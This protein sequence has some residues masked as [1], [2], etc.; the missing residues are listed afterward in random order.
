M[1]EHSLPGDGFPELDEDA[2][3]DLSDL[4]RRLAVDNRAT[5]FYPDEPI[6][7]EGV[8]QEN[9]FNEFSSRIQED[10]DG[11]IWLGHLEHEF[12]FCGHTFGI[13]TLK[14]DEEL[15]AAQVAK[16]YIYD[17]NPF[18][19]RAYA[20]SQIALALVSIDG[21][22][23]FCP[24]VGPDRIAFAKARFQWVT[25]RWYWATGEYLYTEYTALLQRQVEAINAIQDLSNRSLPIS[26]PSVDFSTEPGTS[27]NETTSETL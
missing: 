4:E 3:V 6:E 19:A 11:L 22:E 25:Q 12:E 2:V 23:D 14:A 16:D 5:A 13:R 15:A 27:S 10:I 24:P 21:S 8:P 20:W 17:G 9:P 26:Q 1:A 18:A 7:E